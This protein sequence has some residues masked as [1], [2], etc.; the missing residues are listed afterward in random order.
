MQRL[1]A[2]GCSSA[3]RDLQVQAQAPPARCGVGT[4]PAHLYCQVVT[5]PSVRPHTAWSRQI[6]KLELEPHLNTCFRHF[7]LFTLVRRMCSLLLLPGGCLCPRFRWLRQLGRFQQRTCSSRWC[8]AAGCCILRHLSVAAAASATSCFSRWWAA[9]SYE[10][11]HTV[12]GAAAAAALAALPALAGLDLPS[13]VAA[14][15]LRALSV[16]CTC[17][18]RL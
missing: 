10:V 16:A 9:A 6:E 17:R 4:A 7:I 2:W 13:C 11:R 14:W 15:R 18:G 12:P 1:H 5:F 8:T 3:G